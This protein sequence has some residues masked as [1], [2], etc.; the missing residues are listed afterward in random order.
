MPHQVVDPV[1]I[2]AHVILALHGIVSRR[3]HP[4]DPAVV[5][6][7][8]IHAGEAEN[9][10]PERVELSG[11][12]RYMET[13]VQK[14]IHAEVERGLEIART[15]GGDYTLRIEHGGSPMVNDEGI[16]DL[17]REVAT[18]LLGDDHIQSRRP[19]MGA[20]DFGAFSELAPGAMFS[21]GCLVEGD[22]RKLHSPR[23]DLD[24]G[25]LPI[26]VAILAETALRLSQE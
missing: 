23:F 22:K 15:L 10:I 8:S 4:L 20:E 5:S 3:L 24:E 16:V 12:I 21:L 1:Y 19:E 7:G 11:T 18:S 14:Q 13:E 6:I 17:V 26:G 25:C 2:A 9:V